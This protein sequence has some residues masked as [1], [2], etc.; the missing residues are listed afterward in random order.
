MSSIT[1]SHIFTLKLKLLLLAIVAYCEFWRS[2]AIIV[3]VISCPLIK[4]EQKTNKKDFLVNFCNLASLCNTFLQFRKL[5]KGLRVSKHKV[6][7]P[8]YLVRTSNPLLV[9]PKNISAARGKKVR[10]LAQLI[11]YAFVFHGW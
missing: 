9:I 8:N 2:L 4:K 5:F 11:K 10:G 3:Y 1:H 7:V 6:R